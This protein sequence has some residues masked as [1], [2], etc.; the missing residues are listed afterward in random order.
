[1]WR[2]C[3]PATLNVYLRVRHRCDD[4]DLDEDDNHHCE[5]HAAGVVSLWG[6]RQAEMQCIVTCMGG[7][8]STG[9]QWLASLAMGGFSSTGMQWL[10]SLVMLL[11]LW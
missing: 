7:F 6:A 5:P 1:M 3:Q 11:T 8:S 9:M 10:A 4:T 2:A